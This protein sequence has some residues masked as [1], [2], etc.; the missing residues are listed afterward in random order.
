MQREGKHKLASASRHA[1]DIS[2]GIL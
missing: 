2:E 1:L